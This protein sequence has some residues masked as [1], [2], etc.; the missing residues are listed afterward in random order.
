[1][2]HRNGVKK[3]GRH[4]QHR[5]AL[6]RNMAMA[7]FEHER[8]H[9]T[10][11]KAKVLR[12]FAEPLITWAGVGTLHKRRRVAQEV[13]NP[14][15]LRKLFDEL[16]PRFASRP[17]GYLR[18]LKTGFQRGDHAPTALIELVER[19]APAAEA[20]PAGDADGSAKKAT[21]AKKPKAGKQAAEAAPEA[22]AATEPA[23]E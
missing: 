9:T 13:H 17:G 5:R 19:S 11:T 10:L 4:G 2:R 12:R 21:R 15:V 23:S 6:L 1:M 7:L 16:G 3:L 18:I 20:A 14:K 22:E 8:I